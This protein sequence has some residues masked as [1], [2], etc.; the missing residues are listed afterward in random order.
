MEFKEDKAT[1]S[2]LRA[3]IGKRCQRRQYRGWMYVGVIQAIELSD[4]A[5][6]VVANN[7]VRGQRDVRFPLWQCRLDEVSD[8]DRTSMERDDRKAA[9]LEKAEKKEKKDEK[10]EAKEKKLK[11]RADLIKR[12]QGL[13]GASE[14]SEV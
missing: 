13:A 4:D 5:I 12:L 14:D 6:Y 7:G 1:I 3:L 8:I 9:R 10:A 2:E 11:D